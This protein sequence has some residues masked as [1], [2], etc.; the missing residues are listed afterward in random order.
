MEMNDNAKEISFF[1]KFILIIR[2]FQTH[3]NAEKANF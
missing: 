1:F 2:A 3:F